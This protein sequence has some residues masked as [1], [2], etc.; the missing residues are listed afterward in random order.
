MQFLIMVI[1]AYMLTLDDFGL[2]AMLLV[3][4]SIDTLLANSG[5]GTPLAQRKDAA[6]HE[7][8]TAL[9]FTVGSWQPLPP[10]RNHVQRAL[11]SAPV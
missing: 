4:V 3:F 8:A 2:I 11:Q 6:A 1:L 9:W 10:M 7:K 5:V